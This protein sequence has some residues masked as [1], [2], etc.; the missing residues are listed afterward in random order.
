MKNTIILKFIDLHV[1]KTHLTH[2]VSRYDRNF[3]E[4]LT[5]QFL[6]ILK[7]TLERSV[8]I[9][10]H[11]PVFIVSG[12]V[13]WSCVHHATRDLGHRLESPGP[14]LKDDIP[15][16]EHSFNFTRAL[17][18]I[19]NSIHLRPYYTTRLIKF[20]PGPSRSI[21]WKNSIH[22]DSFTFNVL[23]KSPPGAARY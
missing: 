5:R 15:Q 19:H 22:L 6:L 3:Q 17:S 12:I 4:P 16:T 7:E 23:T 20:Q 2:H 1:S 14:P 10:K 18:H 11:V 21:H 8:R 9:W 13:K